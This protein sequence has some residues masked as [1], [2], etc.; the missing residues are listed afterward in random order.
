MATCLPLQE[1]NVIGGERVPSRLTYIALLCIVPQA[2][3]SKDE[4][5]GIMRG[6]R[7]RDGTVDDG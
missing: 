7:A 1:R 4:R 6:A 2:L 5:G 3:P